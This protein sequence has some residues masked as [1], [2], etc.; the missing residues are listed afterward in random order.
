[1][2]KSNRHGNFTAFDPACRMTGKTGMRPLHITLLTS[3]ESDTLSGM[4]R[5]R[6][7]SNATLVAGRFHEISERSR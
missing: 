2:G 5:S 6:C 1:M 7:S 4:G 3:I